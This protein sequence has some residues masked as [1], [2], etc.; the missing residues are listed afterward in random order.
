M[1][2]KDPSSKTYVFKSELIGQAV[3]EYL[4]KEIDKITIEDLK[5]I[6]ALSIYGNRI[7]S[8]KDEIIIESTENN[9]VSAVI[10]N[11]KKDRK[12]GTIAELD[13]LKYMENLY[14]LTLMKQNIVDLSPIEN[15]K[16]VH[17]HLNDNKIS[18]LKPL[19]NYSQLY[20]LEIGGNPVDDFSSIENMDNLGEIDFSDT[21]IQD[22]SIIADKVKLKYVILKHLNIDTIEFLTQLTELQ[23]LN[24]EN[25]S[26]NDLKVITGLKNLD[27]L[28]ISSNPTTDIESLN[29]SY[30]NNVVINNTRIN[31][32]LVNM[33]INVLKGE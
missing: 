31:K 23:V 12:R 7:A 32:E 29:T 3:A 1:F 16:I 26:I 28:N 21:G 24:L 20:T 18:D 9:Y 17:L 13:D 6:E 14:T 22:F 25:N 33:E 19:K 4:D 11:G 10:I 5:N 2:N 27:Y 30:V 8:S 15:L